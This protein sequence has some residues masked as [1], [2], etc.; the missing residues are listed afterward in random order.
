MNGEK[1]HGDAAADK[2]R[3]DFE[4]RRKEADLALTRLEV[5]ADMQS[6]GEEEDTGVI[7]Q[8]TLER[9]QKREG[10]DPPPSKPTP[11]PGCPRRQPR[12]TTIGTQN[13]PSARPPRPGRAHAG[14]D[15]DAVMR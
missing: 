14:I 15:S 3:E 13:T 6:F 5:R 1:K 9:Q 8:R 11:W 2:W 4:R 10:S 7:D 12:K